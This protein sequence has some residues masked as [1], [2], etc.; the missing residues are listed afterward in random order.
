MTTPALLTLLED[1]PA[2][3]ARE[4]IGEADAERLW[5]EY[6]NVITLDYPSPRTGNQWRLV[7]QGYVGYIPLSPALHLALQPKVPLSNLF[8][9]WAYAYGLEVRFLHSLF[10]C[11]TVRAAYEQ[12]AEVLALR[13]LSRARGGLYRSYQLH[14]EQVTVLRGRLDMAAAVRQPAPTQWPCE[15]EEHTPDNEDNQIVAWT[16]HRIA[17]SGLC[18]EQVQPTVQR[19]CR[20]LA[21]GI[22][23]R[24]FAP[25]DCVGRRYHR[26]NQDY[27][28]L[29]A[30]CRFFLDDAQPTYLNGEQP[31]LPFLVDMSA[32]FE[33]FV[34]AWLQQH[35]PNQ[36]AIKTQERVEL[37]GL[38][39]LRPRIDLVWYERG[40]PRYVLDTKYKAATLP[41]ER[42][43]YQVMAYADF[44]G[45]AE[46]VLVYPSA[47]LPFHIRSRNTRVRTLAFDLAGDLDA[48]GQQ[49][50]AAVL[51]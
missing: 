33:Q 50:V 30:L 12:L 9:M 49:F 48:A 10:Q 11:Q 16:L 24:T 2:F 8:R 5:R 44:K 42:D 25:R 31:M 17:R 13:V 26:L 35:V 32:L 6:A 41:D 15:F 23:L 45:C 1:Q 40:A 47:M 37:I 28:P 3:I 4:V 18:S 34:A 19:A 20:A 27:A 46:A 14:R 36:Y 39:N 7:S 38:G 43:V 51:M 29:H 21:E 22:T